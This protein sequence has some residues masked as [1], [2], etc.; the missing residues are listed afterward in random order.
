MR[1]HHNLFLNAFFG[2]ISQQYGGKENVGSNRPGPLYFYRNV[3]MGYD[4]IAWN[5]WTVI[6]GV[7]QLWENGY[8]HYNN[9]YYMKEGTLYALA[10]EQTSPQAQKSLWFM[11]NILLF[12]NGYTPWYS[13]D[14]PQAQTANNIFVSAKQAD[15]LLVNQGLYLKT[16]QEIGFTKPDLGILVDNTIEN[17]PFDFSLSASSPAVDAGRML[18]AHWPEADR[19]QGNAPD[20][21]A[22][23]HGEKADSH[24]IEYNHE[25]PRPRQTRYIDT[26]PDGFTKIKGWD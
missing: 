17:D 11:N 1:V 4:G 24:G 8:I 3:V 14:Q 12:E 6:K 7:A 20:I 26:V 18:P 2:P 5:S 23:E 16:L 13:A 10:K 22:W 21:G 9:T 15:S 19:Y 25:W